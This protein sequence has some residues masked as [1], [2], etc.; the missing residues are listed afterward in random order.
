MERSYQDPSIVITTYEGQHNHHLPSTL[1]GNVARMLNP[2]MLS[3]PSPLIAAP[4]AFHEQVLMNMAQMP[5]QFYG[6]SAF[7]IN[8]PTN[9]SSNMYHQNVITPHELQQQLQY[10]PD[11]GL[12]QDMVPSMFLKQEP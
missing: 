7:G 2:S 3:T 5:H 8:P 11:Y 1:R 9:S 10:S 4:R 6:S 12:L